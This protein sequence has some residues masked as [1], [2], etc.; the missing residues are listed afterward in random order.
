[1]SYETGTIFNKISRRRKIYV[2]ADIQ[3]LPKVLVYHVN[4]VTSFTKLLSILYLKAHDLLSNN[5]LYGS[6]SASVWF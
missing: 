5:T 4:T 2:H 1:M 6:A 3:S